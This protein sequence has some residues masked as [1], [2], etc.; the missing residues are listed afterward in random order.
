MAYSKKIN[1]KDPAKA[2]A[3]LASTQYKFKSA[4][5]DFQVQVEGEL[6][7]IITRH[8][9]DPTAYKLNAVGFERRIELVRALVGKTPDDEIWPLVKGLGQL[10][11]KYSHS[12]FIETADGKSEIAMIDG[13]NS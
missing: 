6:A 8:F 1:W 10:R 9:Q 3:V 7:D 5:L 12:R 13:Q 4:V 11:N 2:S